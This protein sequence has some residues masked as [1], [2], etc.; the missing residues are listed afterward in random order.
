MESF[1]VCLF[2]MSGFRFDDTGVPNFL[3]S[4]ALPADESGLVTKHVIH[5]LLF[6]SCM[7]SIG[8]FMHKACPSFFGRNDWVVSVASAYQK[9]TFAKC[10][11]NK[12]GIRAA[13]DTMYHAGH[14]FC[15]LPEKYAARS[16]P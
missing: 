16:Q 10:C 9:K 2:I 4:A 12:A 13:S 5:I 14:D 3:A 11:K 6:D 1:L 8:C 7:A 15:I